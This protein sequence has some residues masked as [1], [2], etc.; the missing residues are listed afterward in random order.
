MYVLYRNSGYQFPGLIETRV[1]TQITTR[2][3]EK[4]SVQ[5]CVTL[6]RTLFIGSNQKW[7]II[8]THLPEKRECAILRTFPRG[9][10]FARK[11]NCFPFVM[12]ADGRVCDWQLDRFSRPLFPTAFPDRFSRPLSRS[13]ATF[14]AEFPSRIHS[15]TFTPT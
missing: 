11:L 6:S 7:P 10:I 5:Y 8:G 1:I 9:P 14:S 2:S 15:S 12:M 13:P 3:G 4:T